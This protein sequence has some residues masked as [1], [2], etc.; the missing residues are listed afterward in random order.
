MPRVLRAV[1]FTAIL[2]LILSMGAVSMGALAGPWPPDCS[3][4]CIPSSAAL[5]TP[6]PT[7]T[8]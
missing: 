7:I 2:L 3:D 4:G 1:L 5:P 6:L 8:P